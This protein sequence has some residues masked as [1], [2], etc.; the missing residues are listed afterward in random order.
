MRLLPLLLLALACG[1]SDEDDPTLCSD[2]ADNDADG[3]VDCMEPACAAYCPATTT[4]TVP[5]P[6]NPTIDTDTDTDPSSHDTGF[7]IDTATPLARLEGKVTLEGGLNPADF[8]V[9]LLG[10]GQPPVLTDRSGEWAFDVPEGSYPW[11]ITP[12]AGAGLPVAATGTVVTVAIDP[13]AGRDE[14]DQRLD[15]SLPAIILDLPLPLVQAQAATSLVLTVSDLAPVAGDPESDTLG[16]ALAATPLPVEDVERVYLMYYMRPFA[17]TGT[18][19]VD[20]IFPYDPALEL[21]ALDPTTGRWR[22]FGGFDDIGNDR[23]SATQ[24]LPWVTTI[25]LVEP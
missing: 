18:V 9:E 14:P 17:H 11:R 16:A 2:R 20:F 8:T 12:P 21:W 6:T 15:V 13:D 10:S 7:P 24:T 5:V 22:S 23:I 4:P 1:P 3:L 25:A 19:S